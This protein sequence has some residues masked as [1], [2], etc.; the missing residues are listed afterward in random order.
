MSNNYKELF[1]HYISLTKEYTLT[2][3]LKNSTS[4]TIEVLEK[5]TEP[6]ASYSYQEDKWTIIQVLSHIIDTERIMSYRALRYARQDQTK[7]SGFDENHYAAHAGTESRSI[8]SLLEEFKALRTSTILLFNSFTNEM[9]TYSDNET[10][11]G[12]TVDKLG[13][14]IAGH[15]MHHC[16]ILTE[17][18]GV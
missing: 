3:S 4:Q 17:R 13:R 5:I 7:L 8:N 16:N 14:M 10:G 2:E 15:S 9:L 6:K 18:Y 11:I 1:K 12:L